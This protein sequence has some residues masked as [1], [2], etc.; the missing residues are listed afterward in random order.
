MFLSSLFSLQEVRVS[1]G[2]CAGTWVLSAP[3][4]KLAV[5]LVGRNIGNNISENIKALLHIGFI[6][7]DCP[8]G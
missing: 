3:T 8:D 5:R 7:T 6:S 4:I 2:L 1:K